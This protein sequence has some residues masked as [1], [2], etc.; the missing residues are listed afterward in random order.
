MIDAYTPADHAVID[1]PARRIVHLLWDD[2][3]KIT[4]R[5]ANRDGNFIDV[6]VGGKYILFLARE[7]HEIDPRHAMRI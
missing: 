4:G 1:L 7:V 6:E 5:L 3:A 2:G